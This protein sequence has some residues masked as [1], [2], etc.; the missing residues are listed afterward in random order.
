MSC[1]ECINS[2]KFA[3]PWLW[4]APNQTADISMPGEYVNSDYPSEVTYAVN[5]YGFRSPNITTEEK[6]IPVFAGC[7]FTFGTGLAITDTYVHQVAAALGKE[8]EYLNL[9]LPSTGPDVQIVNLHWA[10]D[11][12]KVDRIFWYMSD[13]HRQIVY[14]DNRF[15][16]YVPGFVK[17][18]K[19]QSLAKKFVEVN[20]MLEDTWWIKNYWAIY[21]LFS[22]IADKKISAHVSC[23]IPEY[24]TQL[25]NLKKQFGI[26]DLGTMKFLDLARDGI[27]HGPLSH[28]YL[29]DSI[30]QNLNE[31]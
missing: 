7:S 11:T 6:D 5:Q 14:Q 16:T 26:K 13:P 25:T 19:N 4:Y 30:L 2:D 28:T 15:A 1:L 17:F 21:G 3:I 27:H 18:F 12:F 24:N 20:A 22:K 9:G 10:I 31:V 23:W 29:K 8:T